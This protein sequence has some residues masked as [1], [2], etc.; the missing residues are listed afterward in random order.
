MICKDEET[1]ATGE[2]AENPTLKI[3]EI[4]ETRQIRYRKK[5]LIQ[6]AFLFNKKTDADIL[7]KLSAVENQTGYIKGLI[8]KDIE[9]NEKINLC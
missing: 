5:N 3:K 7:Q 6:K 4:K 9:K 1:L 2:K 8:R